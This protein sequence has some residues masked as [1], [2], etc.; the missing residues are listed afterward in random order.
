MEYY[1]AMKKSGVLTYA[2]TWINLKNIILGTSLVDQGLRLHTSNAGGTDSILGQGTKIP[3][4]TQHDPKI[5]FYV[6]FII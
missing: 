3:Y 5:Q 4:A 6:F 2:I 1:S